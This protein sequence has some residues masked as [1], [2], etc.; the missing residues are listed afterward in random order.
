MDGHRA[1]R[2][3]TLAAP[4]ASDSRQPLL[5]IEIADVQPHKFA[6]PQA[7]AVQRLKHRPVA[8]AQRR[9]H[10]NRVEQPNHVLDPK[11]LGKPLGLLG[12][13]ESGRGIGLDLA[14]AP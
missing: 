10:W 4:L 1:E 9:V 2:A 8:F 13:A 7:A 12:V 3:E 11:Q 5:E 6:D 14:A